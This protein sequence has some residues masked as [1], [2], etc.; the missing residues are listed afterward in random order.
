MIPC[1]VSPF[2]F[3]GSILKLKDAVRMASKRRVKSLLLA[4]KNFHA[5]VLFNFLCREHGITPVHGLRRDG[6]V[7]YAR[8][9][10]DFQE[11]VQAYNEKRIPEV[12]SVDVS[13]VHHVLY[14]RKNHR[15]AYECM[16]CIQ[17]T[18]PLNGD[19]SLETLSQD[20]SSLNCEPYD[21]KVDFQ[22]P[23]PDDNHW[24]F[25]FEDKLESPLKERFQYEAR[26]IE[27]MGFA[28]YFYVVK[29]IV[30]EAKSLGIRI[31]PG[32][33][34]VV[35]SV[36]SYVLG[37]TQVNPLEFDLL[38]ERFL[39]EERR[40][41]PDID[42]DVEDRKRKELLQALSKRFPFVAQISTFATV[43][44]KSLV[45]DLRKLPRKFSLQR[46]TPL[47]EGL[48]RHLS[49]HAAGV[50]ICNRKLNLPLVSNTDLP[51]LEYDF[52]SLSKIGVTK[53]DILGLRTLSMLEDIRRKVSLEHFPSRD[54][55]TFLNIAKGRTLGVFQLEQPR[56]RD[57][58]RVVRPVNLTE[59][60]ILLSLNRPGPLKGNLP[61]EYGDRKRGCKKSRSVDP[62]LTE[63]L[64][65]PIYQEQIMKLAM[66]V[67]G[68]SPARADSFRKAISQKSQRVMEDA[69]SALKSGMEERGF[70]RSFI[71]ETIKLLKGFS[72]YAFN[73]SHSV[74]YAKLSY[75]IAYLKTH[76]PEEFFEHYLKYNAANSE[77]IFLAVQELRS[78]GIKVLPP[79][80]KEENSHSKTFNLPLEVIP[81]IGPSLA[82]ALKKLPPELKNIR[83]IARTLKIPR[84]VLQD[85]V[86]A[87]VFDEIYGDRELAVKQYKIFVQ[88]FDPDL[89]EIS[90][91]FGKK[92]SVENFSLSELDV[93]KLEKRALG[94]PL[95]PFKWNT[96]K[97][98]SQL[99][100]V[101]SDFRK[102]PVAAKVVSGMASDGQTILSLTGSVQDGE[103]LLVINPDGT[104]ET[105]CDLE[106]VH[107]VVYNV[108]GCFDERDF[109]PASANEVT[110][111]GPPFNVLLNGVRPLIDDF[112]LKVD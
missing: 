70:D 98:F 76:Y 7:Y 109:E 18:E 3:E 47:L 96:T 68:M 87:G 88:G 79:T 20:A 106:Q 5:A 110:K 52:E 73:K 26:I 6:T 100:E 50:V 45:N 66:N 75:W 53:V 103:K 14:L 49:V 92:T 67:A 55:E 62:V 41:P 42:L 60:S 58:C 107:R 48:P 13:D 101:F 78:A 72:G 90:S 30:D 105:C 12:P 97:K 27:K 29:T 84:S 11:M 94:F 54:K 80:L 38:F 22:L 25:S 91:V 32:R 17:Q 40:D 112:Y 8:N 83:D 23:S 64:G 19:F 4:D 93:A 59:L 82:D 63:T 108:S 21:L 81:G 39:N 65:I 1:L 95:T 85:L 102:L 31:G 37:I 33:G 111:L 44:R 35:G 36:V 74:A 57:L 46:V 15:E 89:V 43:T 10:D 69:L 99:S 9:K 77:K 16:C 28:P 61:A 24:L 2:S 51:V 86:H 56:A 104:V 34:S 71:D